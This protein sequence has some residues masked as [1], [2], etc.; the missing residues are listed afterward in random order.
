MFSE[1]SFFY[2]QKRHNS[3]CVILVEDIISLEILR[4]TQIL[5]GGL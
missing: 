1:D 5:F 4:M 2:L 3:K